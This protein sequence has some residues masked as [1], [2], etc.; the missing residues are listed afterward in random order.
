M[1]RCH[2]GRHFN[3]Y[4][5]LF[6]LSL[7][8]SIMLTAAII[9]YGTEGILTRN[10]IA[11]A[12]LQDR[13]VALGE[14]IATIE[15]QTS[16]KFIYNPAQLPMTKIL[17]VPDG[18]DGRITLARLFTAVSTQ[19]PV[20]FNV[21]GDLIAI[22]NQ[23]PGDEIVAAPAV[24]ALATAGQTET[25]A[26]G[27]T[28]TGVPA[29]GLELSSDEVLQLPRF[30]AEAGVVRGSVNDMR[31]M[32]KKAAVAIDYM[33]AT[34][35]AKFSAGDLSDVV[36]RMPG[37]SVADGQ[38]AVVRGLS[39]RFLS[40]TLNGLKL[41][42][43]DPEKQAVQLDLLPTSAVEAVVVSK[44][45]QPS[46]WAE[47]SAGNMD[48]LTRSIPEQRVLNIGIGLK[49]NGNTSD[50]DLHYSTRGGVFRERF[51]FGSHSRLAAGTT[52]DPN[53]QYVPTPRN[54]V[55]IGTKLSVEYANS[56]A[57]GE[58]QR[59]GLLISASNEA[60]Y[61]TRRGLR[62]SRAA[63]I[64]Q[65]AGIGS[66]TNPGIAS[67][68]EQRAP[69]PSVVENIYDYEESEQDYVTSVSASVGYEF[70]PNHEIKLFAA[71]VQSGNDQSQISETTLTTDPVTGD[72]K[73]LGPSPRL[74]FDPIYSFYRANEY[75]RERNLTALQLS[76]RHAFG[77]LEMTWVGQRGQSYQKDHPFIESEFV[78]P[79]AE[80]HEV[81][82][83]L[84]GNDAPTPI[85]SVWGD[86]EETQNAGRLDFKL[87]FRLWGD[88]DTVLTFGAAIEASK[89]DVTGVGVVT[90][91][92]ALIR[93]SSPN[94]IISRAATA[95]GGIFESASSA[96]RKIAAYHVNLSLPVFSWLKLIGGARFEDFSLE[97][98][99][100][101]RWGNYTTT[102]L[103]NNTVGGGQFGNILGTTATGNTP[104]ESKKWYPGMGL[105]FQFTDSFGLRLAYSRTSG[106]P[107]FREV[108][109][110]FNKSIG[111][112]NLVVGNPA[113][114]PSEVK[115]YDA[116]IEW[117]P[118]KEN[119]VSVSYFQKKIQNPIEK[120]LLETRAV[121][122]DRTEIWVNNPGVA[123]VKGAE[124][125]FRYGLGSWSEALRAFSLSG[126]FTKITA[127]V[128]EHPLV[129]SQ[130][131]RFFQDP[132][133]M[134]MVRRLF[135]QPEYIGNLDFTWASPRLGTTLTLA[136]YAISDTLTVAGLSTFN[137]DLYER[138]YSQIDFIW[139]QRLSDSFKLKVAV[140]N[141]TD[142]VRGLIYDREAT[143]ELVERTTYQLGR[144][145]SVTVNANF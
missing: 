15:D 109:P 74:N 82:L 67:D 90:K 10:A 58:E 142:P 69:V 60:S 34:D 115:N 30:E 118:S 26:A 57:I 53:W 125:E 29:P 124:F 80:L 86:N 66:A 2:W 103:Y 62:Q 110:F 135:D 106:R 93:G 5:F 144:E 51:G 127:E 84:P 68:F 36:F 145:Y 98:E 32:K 75:F 6:T 27:E 16:F 55:P 121:A 21:R 11:L 102:T 104:F 13:T 101:G 47:S 87:P 59:L 42:S 134:A 89:R 120:I 116:R 45:Y 99:G 43:P 114:V 71:Y 14:V 130:N 100:V 137:F 49:F 46:L 83:V 7:A 128:P 111:T 77:P 12:P 31:S 25:W 131:E 94:A 97:T 96:D 54:N 19:V 76:G 133:K 105:N 138:A 1:L 113:L 72:P 23:A 3:R 129:L 41:P 123:D 91:A 92:N 9:D 132:A 119:M 24:E 48:I 70:S 65:S 38:F 4:W 78:S 79:L 63:A 18:S 141:L 33:S 95:V 56:I 108:S 20:V 39:D 22:W 44:T 88:E 37:I 126:N 28:G 107:S 50:G 61:K 35:L 8:P 64:G 140:K 122:S 52:S 81:Y 117:N 139:S 73:L 112:G 17:A 136:G 40:T 85:F 143:A